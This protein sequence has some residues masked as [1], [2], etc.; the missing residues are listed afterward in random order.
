MF[1][2]KQKTRVKQKNS[3]LPSQDL[4]GQAAKSLPAA[5]P[6][7]VAEGRAP[8]PGPS[9][10]SPSE[11]GAQRPGL[12]SPIPPL[13]PPEMQGGAGGRIEG[14]LFLSLVSAVW[15]T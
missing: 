8:D 6:H 3:R 15:V 4:S 7:R 1:K 2:N 13:A 9:P 5:A 11:V 12:S 10:P 14:V